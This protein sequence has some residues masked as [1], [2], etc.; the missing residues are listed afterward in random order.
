MSTSKLR[1]CLCRPVQRPVA[2]SLSSRRILFVEMNFSRLGISY[3]FTLVWPGLALAFEAAV[4]LF[5]TLDTSLSENIGVYGWCLSSV[6][7]F[8]P[9]HLDS[10]SQLTKPARRRLLPVLTTGR[11][12]QPPHVDQPLPSGL[13]ACDGL[14]STGPPARMAG[15]G[16]A[17]SGWPSM[18]A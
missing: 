14:A 18:E 12:D 2:R 10:A 1:S 16:V 9:L 15:R 17:P 4:T 6:I 11:F 13:P 7:G 8:L 3:I 5:S